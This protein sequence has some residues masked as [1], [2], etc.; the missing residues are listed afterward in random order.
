[1]QFSTSSSFREKF[2]FYQLSRLPKSF[3]FSYSSF[4]VEEKSFDIWLST[5]DL[6][7]CR[8][9]SNYVDKEVLSQSLQLDEHDRLSEFSALLEDSQLS[10]ISEAVLQPT[11]STDLL[12][13]SSD[14]VAVLENI[15]P[16]S[17][18]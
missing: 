1:M 10:G 6:Y 16:S 8:S 2:K 15:S 4:E 14:A 11:C 3:E 18:L 5:L 13:S 9:S 12:S 17:M 7:I